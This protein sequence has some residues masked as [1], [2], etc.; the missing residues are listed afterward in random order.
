M[1]T[2]KDHL[3]DVSGYRLEDALK[4]LKSYGVEKIEI[5]QTAPP[6]QRDAAQDGNSRVIRQVS[7]AEHSVELLVCNIDIK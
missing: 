7:S 2:K 3:P 4:V 6:R 1:L 5:L